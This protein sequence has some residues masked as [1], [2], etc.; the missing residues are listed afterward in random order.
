MMQNILRIHLSVLPRFVNVLYT[1]YTNKH[2]DG[3]LQSNTASYHNDFTISKLIIVAAQFV[4]SI[5]A[6]QQR[7]EENNKLVPY[8]CVIYQIRL[9]VSC[10]PQQC[11]RNLGISYLYAPILKEIMKT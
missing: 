11:G 3:R 10:I 4:S 5:T 6:V 9:R 2:E 1:A 8:L 7:F